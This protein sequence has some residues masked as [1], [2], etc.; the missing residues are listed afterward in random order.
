MPIVD[1]PF[2]AQGVFS[3]P[4]P[5][6]PILI[7]NPD[8][9]TK[10]RTWGLVDTGAAAT[11]IPAYIARIIGHDVEVVAPAFGRGAGGQFNVY[12]HTCSIEFFSMDGNGIVN[13][14][15]IVITIPPRYIGITDNVDRVLLGVQDFL[16][17]YI[18]KI[19]YPRQIISIRHPRPPQRK[20]KIKRRKR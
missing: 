17:R 14:N 7:T 4:S 9:G 5:I 19:D 10:F 15:D 12:P 1:Y 3:E 8:T 18:L 11:V 16:K 13:E 6:L 2:Q 20:K